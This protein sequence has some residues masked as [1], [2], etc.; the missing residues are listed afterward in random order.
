[1]CVLCDVSGITEAALVADVTKQTQIKEGFAKAIGVVAIKVTITNIGST[2]LT[3]SRT[4]T[5]KGTSKVSRQLQ[6]SNLKIKFEITA[7]SEDDAN[8]LKTKVT[9]TTAAAITTEI[10]A[11]GAGG[12]A[13]TSAPTAAVACKSGCKGKGVNDDAM[14][15]G[16]IAVV[17]VLAAIGYAI[18]ACQSKGSDAVSMGDVE[19]SLSNV[20]GQSFT[21]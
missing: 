16:G 5:I 20:G 3:S 9:T 1:M 2:V 18:H 8:A 13:A 12:I 19:S 21:V 11:A 4:L 6:T 7:D 14:I 15:G 17:V 10:V